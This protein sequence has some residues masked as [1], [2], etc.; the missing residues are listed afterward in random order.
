MCHRMG[1]IYDIFAVHVVS[2][3]IQMP[4]PMTMSKMYPDPSITG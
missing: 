3:G 4:A 2:L 1:Y